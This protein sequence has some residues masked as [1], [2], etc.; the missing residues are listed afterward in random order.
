MQGL[1]Y[2]ALVSPEMRDGAASRTRFLLLASG[3][4]VLVQLSCVIEEWIFKQMLPN[5][6]FHWFVALVELVLFTV[7]GHIGH[8][9]QD[10]HG[11]GSMPTR[12]GPFSLYLVVGLSL[13]GGTGLGKVAYRYL[14][15][16]TGTVLK[17]M[18]LLPVMG[19]SVC[20]LRR[21]YTWLQ[22]IA[23]SL[24]VSSAACFGLGEAEL[25]HATERTRDAGPTLYVCL[26]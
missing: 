1:L 11:I 23:A 4:I 9:F 18:K 3:T 13:A 16:A 24:M 21:R 5:F 7:L 14:N 22:C 19:L 25:G 12:K 20:W 15:Y 2:V 10:G 8:A 26:Q 6:T 17:S